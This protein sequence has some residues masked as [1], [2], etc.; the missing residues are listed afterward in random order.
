MAQ[1]TL[2]EKI[3]NTGDKSPGVPRIGLP[4]Y[5]WWSEALHGVARS[6]GVKFPPSGNFSYATSFP[7]P[8]SMGAAFDMPLVRAVAGECRQ[9][10]ERAVR[11][12][13]KGDEG[14]H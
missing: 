8:I 12:G 14:V 2:Q 9:M 13:G 11:R 5:E 3:Q 4:A 6:P 1:F 10:E 7:Q